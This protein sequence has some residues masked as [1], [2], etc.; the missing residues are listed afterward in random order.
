MFVIFQGRRSGRSNPRRSAGI[1][2]AWMNADLPSPAA[3]E[4]IA[5]PRCVLDSFHQPTQGSRKLLIPSKQKTG[6]HLRLRSNSLTDSLTIR[7]RNERRLGKECSHDFG[8]RA[9]RFR[10]EI[11][12]EAT[13]AAV[14]SASPLFLS[15]AASGDRHD[16]RISALAAPRSN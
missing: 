12:D 13:G 6:V 15:Q 2:P 16:S 7:F 10:H 9:G 11:R 1:T 4:I 3:P 5:T 8:R 14:G